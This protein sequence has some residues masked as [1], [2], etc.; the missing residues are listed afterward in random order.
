[1]LRKILW[2]K[3]VKSVLFSTTLFLH[4]EALNILAF[5][6][7]IFCP[8]IMA[9]LWLCCEI[10]YCH[11][12]VYGMVCLQQSNCCRSVFEFMESIIQQLVYQGMIQNPTAEFIFMLLSFPCRD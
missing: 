1:M 2:R 8:N 6:G 3:D 5:I 7:E 4:L 11:S 9:R 12:S 10:P